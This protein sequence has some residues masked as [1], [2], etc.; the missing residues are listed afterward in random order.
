MNEVEQGV[1]AGKTTLMDSLV[2]F[3]MANVSLNAA[4]CNQQCYLAKLASLAAQIEANGPAVC[5]L[6]ASQRT[7]SSVSPVSADFC[8]HQFLNCFQ[9]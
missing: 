1:I 2:L 3:E 7:Y 8:F 6:T 4:L 5:L 9:N